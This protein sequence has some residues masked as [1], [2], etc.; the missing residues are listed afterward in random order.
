MISN[1]TEEENLINQISS[2]ILFFPKEQEIDNNNQLVKVSK[3]TKDDSKNTR[4]FSNSG[5][6][7]VEKIVTS[8]DE[9]QLNTDTIE[10]SPNN[11]NVVTHQQLVK[12]LI[13]EIIYYLDTITIMTRCLAI[14]KNILNMMNITM[15]ERSFSNNKSLSAYNNAYIVHSSF[16][17][18]DFLLPGEV[19]FDVEFKIESKDQGWA[20]VNESSSWVEM[21]ISG[22]SQ[23]KD[24]Y[25][26][27]VVPL[28]KNFK[29]KKFKTINVIYSGHKNS[30]CDK[31]IFEK[32]KNRNN[33]V[34]IIA[35]CMYG[36]WECHINSFKVIFRV[37][38]VN[39]Q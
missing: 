25:I 27:M 15:E 33:K 20:S 23:K 34:E 22:F 6:C 21:K 19:L 31:N 35:R 9:K 18:S 28:A 36:G 16:D 26:D 32:L 37:L 8:N 24:I 17:I 7:L 12:F 1:S 4:L 29:E 11:N 13:R 3:L 38:K 2:R 39:R 14:N 10:Y 30:N 5:M